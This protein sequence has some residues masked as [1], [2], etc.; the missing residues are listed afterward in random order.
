MED[1]PALTDIAEAPIA[2]RVPCATG[3]CNCSSRSSLCSDCSSCDCRPSS[4]DRRRCKSCGVRRPVGRVALAASSMANA[5]ARTAPASPRGKSAGRGSTPSSVESSGADRTASAALQNGSGGGCR[6]GGMPSSD[7]DNRSAGRGA[8]WRP[9]CI[10]AT[11]AAAAVP[12]AVLRHVPSLPLPFPS[13]PPSMP[14]FPLS[15][16]SATFR[17]AW[18]AR[19]ERASAAPIMAACWAAPACPTMVT[20]VTRDGA[21]SP[22]AV[23]GKVAATTPIDERTAGSH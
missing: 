2:A 10:A 12:A 7:R 6:S 4:A 3:S 21:V 17:R 19:T 5:A 20:I 1:G 15:V 23:E 11:A 16:A 14:P 18:M 9:A 13:V 22:L 8:G